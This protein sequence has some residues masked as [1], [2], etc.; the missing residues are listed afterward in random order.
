MKGEDTAAFLEWAL[1]AQGLTPREAN[2]F[3]I[4]W[5]PRMEG[6]PYNVISFQ[7]KT[8]TDTAVLTITPAPDTLLRVFMA[9][10][11]SEEAVNIP[12][13]SFE[14]MERSGFTAVE[15]GGSEVGRP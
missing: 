6:N 4:Y 2:E 13:Q 8:Y 7:T 9:W 3:I 14:P 15:W 5:L 12:A 1:A 10:Y 11:P